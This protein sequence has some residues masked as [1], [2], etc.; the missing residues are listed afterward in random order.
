MPKV[1]DSNTKWFCECHVW[2]LVA[3]FTIESVSNFRRSWI[4]KM[5]HASAKQLSQVQVKSPR[6][7]MHDS[8]DG[9][10][11]RLTFDRVAPEFHL[12]KQEENEPVWKS[13]TI[14]REEDERK[15]VS[16]LLSLFYGALINLHTAT[17]I[18]A[19]TCSTM[20]DGKRKLPWRRTDE[21]AK[22]GQI[23][24]IPEQST[25]QGGCLAR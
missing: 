18:N 2:P 4:W 24:F 16:L 15:V 3:A 7:P 19:R 1:R 9:T 11:F 10:L 25:V 22:W 21:L 6:G 17:P 14:F 12:V 5:S 20:W 23:L 8:Y 13:H